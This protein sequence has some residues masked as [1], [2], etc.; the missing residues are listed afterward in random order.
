LHG[1]LVIDDKYARLLWHLVDTILAAVVAAL[2]PIA[3]I[4]ISEATVTDEARERSDE[5]GADAENR[6]GS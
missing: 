2:A 3:G 1:G 5:S 4:G 6:R